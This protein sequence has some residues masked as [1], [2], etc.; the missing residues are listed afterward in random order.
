LPF[1]A[2]KWT[3]IFSDVYFLFTVAWGLL[4]VL[5]RHFKPGPVLYLFFCIL[6]SMYAEL[7]QW[8]FFFFFLFLFAYLYEDRKNIYLVQAGILAIIGFYCK[9][10]LGMIL[11]GLFLA[12]ITLAL[13]TRKMTV[14]AYLLFFSGFIV[15]TVLLA[16]LLHTWLPGYIAGGFHYLSG[17]GDSMF[18]APTGDLGA[19][20]VRAAVLTFLFFFVCCVVLLAALIRKR[21][22]WA[23]L[24]TLFL[25][26][27]IA[28]GL[29]LLF[30]SSFIRADAIHIFRFF[31]VTGLFFFFLYLYTPAGYGKKI[32]AVFSW[33]VVGIAFV[34]SSVFLPDYFQ[35]Y[36]RVVRFSLLPIKIREVGSYLADCRNYERDRARL[37]SLTAL[38]NQYKSMIGTRPVDIIPLDVA[39][40]YFHG[41]NYDPRPT[42]QSYSTNDEY[43]DRLNYKKYTGADAPDFVLFRLGAIDGR[44]A[45]AEESRVYLALMTHYRMTGEID[46]QLLLKKRGTPREFTA[47]PER[48]TKLKMG[49]NFPIR[50]QSGLQFARFVIHY[51]WPGR[52]SSFFYQ[53]PPLNMVFIL[54]N[55]EEK[56]CRVRRPALADGFFINKY[57]ADTREFQLLLQADGR[58]NADVRAIRLE[59]ADSAKKGYADEITMVSREYSFDKK[60]A[61]ERLA[62]S[63]AIAALVN[64]GGMLPSFVPAPVVAGNSELPY[65]IEDVQE[66]G[67]LFRISGWAYRKKDNSRGD[68]AMAVLRSDK[69]VY[70]LPSEN[71]DRADLQANMSGRDLSGAGFSSLCLRSQLP[72]GDYEWGIAV[73][74]SNRSSCL[75]TYTGKYITTNNFT[76][77]PIARLPAVSK[78]T[79]RIS[80]NIEKVDENDEGATV[81]GW[82]VPEHAAARMNT[83]LLLQNDT[84]AYRVKTMTKRRPDIAAAYHDPLFESAGFSVYIPYSA[85]PAGTYTIGIRKTDGE[86]RAHNYVFSGKKLV[87]RFNQVRPIGLAGLPAAASFPG[88]IDQVKDG[89]RQITVSGWAVSRAGTAQQDRIRLVLKGET[90]VYAVAT[91]P[92]SRPD[93]V[94]RFH[95]PATQHCGFIVQFPHAS[96]PPGK[97]RLGLLVDHKNGSSELMFL[98]QSITSYE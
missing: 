46:G 13:V 26:G 30:K 16:G 76:P 34:I 97:Y 85:L 68:R 58:L 25:Y 62:D 21:Q 45:W 90:A 98:D 8:C 10:N 66:N 71:T 28:M 39:S 43:L 78:D 9:L 50:N 74:D 40:V 69:G 38:P 70:V 57:L 67:D 18:L 23:Q 82:A 81:E 35:P 51:N 6:I 41:L 49:E 27:V 52:L 2:G 92:V 44:Y 17:Y 59:P 64:G 83:E 22:F 65:G 15:S 4:I 75:V 79:G 86:G 77:V 94:S 60:S 88:N 14:K 61:A 1:S 37:D 91:D 36:R 56:T 7:Y 63:L 89:D 33:A 47:G 48:V 32:A 73:C 53:P 31:E 3:Y 87:V 93:I 11:M 29:F 80:Y 5:R 12:G 84:A 72:E 24:Q 95:D 54:N 20:A 19:Y 42:L 55:G 96:L